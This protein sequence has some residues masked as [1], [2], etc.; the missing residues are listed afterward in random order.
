MDGSL[1]TSQEH[2]RELVVTQWPGGGALCLQCVAAVL[3]EALLPIRRL[4]VLW[5]DPWRSA[6]A[7]RWSLRMR[8]CMPTAHAFE[9]RR[10]VLCRGMWRLMLRRDGVFE[11]QPTWNHDSHPCFG[12]LVRGMTVQC[13]HGVGTGERGSCWHRRRSEV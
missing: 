7:V 3:Q 8:T 5:Y 12:M 4:T 10:T 6:C 13:A 1:H 11:T 9:G 2:A